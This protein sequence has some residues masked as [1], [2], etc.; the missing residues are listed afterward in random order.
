MSL[1]T[2]PEE[3]LQL[4]VFAEP[5]GHVR[6]YYF[7]GE[8]RV[9]EV[10]A[11][12][13]F[14]AIDWQM[15]KRDLVRAEHLPLVHVPL[16]PLQMPAAL[17]GP[18]VADEVVARCGWLDYDFLATPAS[19]FA[20]QVAQRVERART[21]RLAVDEAAAI[22][23]SA[24]TN[25]RRRT[26]AEERASVLDAL[27]GGNLKFFWTSTGHVVDPAEAVDL[28]CRAYPGAPISWSEAVAVACAPGYD[29]MFTTLPALRAWYV[30]QTE[31]QFDL[32]FRR[33]PSGALVASR[34]AARPSED[35]SQGA[36]QVQGSTHAAA[37]AIPP[38]LTY[39]KHRLY[40]RIEFIDTDGRKGSCR[41]AIAVLRALRDPRLTTPSSRPQPGPDTLVWQDDSGAWQEVTKKTIANALGAARRWRKA[42]VKVS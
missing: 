2:Q 11:G 8:R 40:E 10:C 32:V 6:A 33:D 35:R 41:H 27:A 14:D 7:D 28:I 23:A 38:G 37:A 39:W 29:A 5:D 36:Q 15:W 34:T 42:P 16:C 1:A 17:T 21:E 18:L 30:Q 20:L 26:I 4:R 9:R 31:N 25:D 24:A 3:A 12:L 22:L 19:V 13:N